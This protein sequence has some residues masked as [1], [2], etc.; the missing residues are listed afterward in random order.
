MDLAP[1]NTPAAFSIAVTN[2]ADALET[3]VSVSADGV[4]YTFHDTTI[5]SLTTGTGI[6]TTLNSSYLD[7]VQIRAGIGT[8][9]EPL[10]IGK[11]SEY[12]DIAKANNRKIYPELKRLR[13]NAD[14]APIVQAVMD[15]GMGSMC[16]MSAFQLSR[17]QIVR[18]ITPV[19]EVG[20][21]SDSSDP[22]ELTALVDEL[23]ALGN[24]SMIVNYTSTLA[25]PSVVAYA[26]ANGVGWA[27]YIVPDL[28]TVNALNAI[29]VFRIISNTPL[30]LPEP[31]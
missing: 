26:L 30:D 7:S 13:S 27:T 23:I 16:N 11:F 1:Q 2:G 8:E 21:L 17:I 29:N 5:D 6:F 4:L 12:L 15:A 20:M 22:V 24:A 3:D 14:V 19:I 28:A 25:N 9:Y 10:R 18:S 31:P